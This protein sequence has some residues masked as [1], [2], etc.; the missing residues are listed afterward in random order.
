MWQRLITTREDRMA[1][2]LRLALAFLIFPHGAQ[3][4]LGWFGGPGF[5]ATIGFFSNSLGVPGVLVV[6]VIVVE[7]FGPVGLLLGLLSRVAAFGIACVMAVA[8]LMV[9]RP[10]GFFMNWSGSQQGKGFEYHLLALAIVVAVMIKGTGAL[11]LDRR[12]TIARP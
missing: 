10:N 6:L 11:S 2:L 4:L 12:L 7:F 8:T 1:L 5:S 3:K 9:H